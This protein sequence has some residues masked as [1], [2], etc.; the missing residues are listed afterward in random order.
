MS[1]TNKSSNDDS[2]FLCPDFYNSGTSRHQKSLTYPND[3][4]NILTKFMFLTQLSIFGIPAEHILDY[5]PIVKIIN[6]NEIVYAFILDSSLSR[7]LKISLMIWTTDSSTNYLVDFIQKNNKI[8]LKI[9]NKIFKSV[10]D[11]FDDT[12][13]FKNK[14]VTCDSSFQPFYLKYQ[15]QPIFEII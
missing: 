13:M 8:Y 9:N 14:N 5:A 15:I 11:L 4:S 6:K 1:V 7:K 3:K 10:T 2:T 12:K